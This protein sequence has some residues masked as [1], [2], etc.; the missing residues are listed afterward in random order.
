VCSPTRFVTSE[1]LEDQLLSS[2][3]KSEDMRNNRIAYFRH[4]SLLIDP[5]MVQIHLLDT[6]PMRQFKKL[7]LLVKLLF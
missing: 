2:I 7:S 1:D 6:I 5:K 3:N 4:Y